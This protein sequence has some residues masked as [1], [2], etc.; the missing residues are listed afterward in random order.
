MK[1]ETRGSLGVSGGQEPWRLSHTPPSAGRVT[2][3]IL[4]Q[5]LR[6]WP[7]LGSVVIGQLGPD[8]LVAGPLHPK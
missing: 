6:P 4:P 7:G 3:N 8:I 2:V 1:A 5:L